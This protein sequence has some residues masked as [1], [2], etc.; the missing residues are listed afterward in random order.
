MILDVHRESLRLRIKRRSFGNGPRQQDAL[1]FKP[2]IV[3]Q[4][5]REMFLDAK[6]ESLLGFRLLRALLCSLDVTRRLWC[7]FE[8]ALLFVFLQDHIYCSRGPTPA[9]S[10]SATSRLAR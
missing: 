7:R 9:R 8:V 5:T 2:E 1:P 4:M 6:E 3:V 10:R